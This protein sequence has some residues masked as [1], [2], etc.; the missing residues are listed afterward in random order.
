MFHEYWH[1]GTPQCRRNMVSISYTSTRTL[2]RDPASYLR[3]QL[4]V[5]PSVR[6]YDVTIFYYVRSSV[7]PFVTFSTHLPM[8]V[9]PFVRLSYFQSSRLSV[10]PFVTFSTHP[11]MWVCP[12]VRLSSLRPSPKKACI[13]C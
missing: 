6:M 1:P 2:A 13:A 4:S 5:R 10:C 7:R 9:C 8:C 3:K 11:P 12:F